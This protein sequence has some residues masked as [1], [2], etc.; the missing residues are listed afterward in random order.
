MGE[1]AKAL[2]SAAT[3][4]RKLS[5]PLKLNEEYTL[6]VRI[7]GDKLTVT[8]QGIVMIEAHDSVLASGEFGIEWSAQGVE[9]PVNAIEDVDLDHAP[10]S[11]PKKRITP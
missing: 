6:E 7:V 4:H 1:N 5:A 9:Q 8:L 2:S 10:D 3:M 11:N